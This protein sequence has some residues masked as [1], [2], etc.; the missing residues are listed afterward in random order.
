MYVWSK[1]IDGCPTLIMTVCT[2]CLELQIVGAWIDGLQ[3]MYQFINKSPYSIAMQK[4]LALGPHVGLDPQREILCTVY[5]HVGIP[6][7]KLI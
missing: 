2:L 5:Q 1:T 3:L 6:Y 4:T 7:T